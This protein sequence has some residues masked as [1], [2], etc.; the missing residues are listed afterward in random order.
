M[1]NIGSKIK[2]LRESK[3]LSRQA[4]ADAIQE[5]PS[6]IQDIERGKQRPPEDFLKKIIEFFQI[7]ANWMF[8]EEGINPELGKMDDRPIGR[9]LIKMAIEIVEEALAQTQRRMTP[10]KKAEMVLAVAD[11][12]ESEAPNTNKERILKL[13]KFVA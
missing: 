6:K 13:V 5:K 8:S 4:L 9:E 10:A 3:G 1:A 2:G 12:L 7:D 11:L